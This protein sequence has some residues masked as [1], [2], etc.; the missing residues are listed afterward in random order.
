[1]PHHTQFKYFKPKLYSD[2]NEDAMNL[3]WYLT[4][5]KK[6]AAGFKTIKAMGKKSFIQC[7][8]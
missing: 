4:K 8:V 7:Q 5:K 2:L 1:M 6:A 3:V